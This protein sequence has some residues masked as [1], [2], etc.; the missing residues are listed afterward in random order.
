MLGPIRR[1]SVHGESRLKIN[2][3]IL[4]SPVRVYIYAHIIVITW[5]AAAGL[6]Q[7]F[8]CLGAN[9]GIF[10]VTICST[11]SPPL[12]MKRRLIAP[13]KDRSGENWLLHV[14]VH[15]LFLLYTSFWLYTPP[16]GK[17][18]KSLSSP[19]F[20]SNNIV[21][22]LQ[23]R[24]ENCSCETAIVRRGKHCCPARHNWF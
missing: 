16:P 17:K 22:L 7:R 3:V 10:S 21:P 23:K 14:H 5:V 9:S 1:G 13:L 2:V 4:W 6:W 20:W 19:K 18:N 24:E 12:W 15:N 8:A 11:K